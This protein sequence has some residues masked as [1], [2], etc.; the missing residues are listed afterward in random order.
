[1]KEPVRPYPPLSYQYEKT[2]ERRYIYTFWE[3]LQEDDG[4]D[5]GEKKPEKPKKD[6]SKVD[7]AW[8][9]TQIPEGISPSQIKIEFGYNANCMAYED[10][11]VKFYYEETIPARKEEYK[12]AKKK[13]E[14]ENA[15]YEK[16]LAEYKLFLHNKE[17]E[18][19]EQ[20]LARLKG[21]EVALDQSVDDLR[22][23]V[24]T[25][26]ALEDSGVATL[27]KLTHKTPDELL[28]LP[29]FGETGLREVRDK[30]K[31]LGLTLWGEDR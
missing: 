7:L 6:I 18:E 23:S 20:K 2:V 27:E 9:L 15:Q 19:T 25:T 10:H 26:R 28:E 8:L 24:R 21:K 5:D 22:F 14:E 16:D 3:T 31:S 13:Y 12:A 11:Y 30:L 17:I 29:R 1:M 4:W